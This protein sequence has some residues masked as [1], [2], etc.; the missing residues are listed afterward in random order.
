MLGKNDMTQEVQKKYLDEQKGE[1]FHLFQYWTCYMQ[2]NIP[3]LKTIDQPKST[4]ITKN[5]KPDPKKF[6]FSAYEFYS[7]FLSIF[8]IFWYVNC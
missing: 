3:V 6:N 5:I 8:F 2:L 1:F 7:N 4:I